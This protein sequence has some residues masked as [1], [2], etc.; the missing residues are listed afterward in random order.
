M[1]LDPLSF[2]D[3]PLPPTPTNS[4]FIGSKDPTAQIQRHRGD[5][6]LTGS[7]AGVWKTYAPRTWGV[8]LLWTLGETNSLETLFGWFYRLYDFRGSQFK[9]DTL[10]IHYS[11]LSLLCSLR[12]LGY[13]W[14]LQMCVLRDP[15]WPC[16]LFSL[17]LVYSDRVYLAMSPSKSHHSSIF[18]N[19]KA[20]I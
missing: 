2:K 19:F 14:V 9:S 1:E 8:C 11:S 20:I 6:L 3:C 16:R 18:N 12:T 4:R 15:S 17:A 7:R 13:C 10:I 5:L